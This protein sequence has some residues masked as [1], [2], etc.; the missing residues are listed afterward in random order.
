VPRLSVDA[1]GRL[2]RRTLQCVPRPSQTALRILLGPH[3]LE[4]ATCR[5]QWRGE[6]TD[7][8]RVIDIAPPAP[9][10]SREGGGRAE[11]G[12]RADVPAWHGALA[13]LE[14]Q[15]PAGA[16]ARVDVV[17]SN[18]LVRFAVLPWVAGLDGADERD[19][20]ARNA[21]TQAHGTAAEAWAL[22]FSDQAWG[23]PLLASAVDAALLA[24]LRDRLAARGLRLGSVQ[25]LFAWTFNRWRTQIA[26]TGFWFVAAEPRRLCIARHGA[27]GWESVRSHRVVRDWMRELPVLLTRE[28]LQSP[29]AAGGRVYVATPGLAGQLVDGEWTAAGLRLATATAPVEAATPVAAGAP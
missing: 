24:A 12:T 11:S 22:R 18:E 15:L 9:D 26:E 29:S 19:G 10:A 21:F 14:T 16:P 20:L 25:P 27:G 7:A 1:L 28:R 23:A 8:P 5:W 3:A 13:I 17:L 4:L 6:Q 2:A